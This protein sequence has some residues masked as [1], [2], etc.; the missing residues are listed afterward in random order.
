MLDRLIQMRTAVHNLCAIQKKLQLYI[1]TQPEWSLLLQLCSIPAIFVK[2]TRELW[3]SLY[4]TL[5]RQLP[6]FIYLSGRLEDGLDQ[7][8]LSEPDSELH[9]AVNEAWNELD[10]YQ[11]KTGLAQAVATILDPRCELYSLNS[12]HWRLEE[13]ADAERQITTLYN[14]EYAPQAPSEAGTPNLLNENDDDSDI[15]Y[16]IYSSQR[17]ASQTA[18][19]RSELNI[20]LMEPLEGH[21]ID[22]IG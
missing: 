5:S 8:R 15:F 3:A 16:T 12:L 7:L 1:L 19:H 10:F 9:A 20:Y 22:P 14:K 21:R 13:I 11:L 4:P 2:G 17:V 18:I 6:Y